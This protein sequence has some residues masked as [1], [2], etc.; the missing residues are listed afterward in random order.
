[1]VPRRPPGVGRLTAA[2]RVL[3]GAGICTANVGLAALLVV[4]LGAAGVASGR[5]ALHPG[6]K[7]A[8]KDINVT[9]SDFR[10]LATMTR[11]RGF[12]LS[13]PLGHLKQALKVANSPKGGVYPVG[14][15][16]QLVPQE[17]MVK[18]RKGFSRAS[19]DWEFFSLRTTA[20]GTTI[21]TRGTTTVVNRFGGS[22]LSCHMAAAP[23]FDFVCEHNHWCA[24]L[25]VG[26][27]VIAAVQRADPRPLSLPPPTG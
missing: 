10:N 12:F 26:D 2:R 17:A 14:T 8:P 9:A 21:L 6:S 5:D 16:I 7:P 23:Q 3:H 22:C 20:L 24:P 27:D 19:H 1:M 15:I 25:P 13:N 11:V 4:L 18:R